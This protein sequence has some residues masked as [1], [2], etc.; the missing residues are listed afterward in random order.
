[1][2]LLLVPLLAAVLAD[3]GDRFQSDPPEHI[4]MLVSADGFEPLASNRYHPEGRAAGRFDI[5][6]T[7]TKS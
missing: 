7:P 6:L 5:V 4:H 3:G 1:M 2:R